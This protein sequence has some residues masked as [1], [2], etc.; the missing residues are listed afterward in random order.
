MTRR[1]FLG[2][3]V[4]GAGARVGTG[5]TAGRS[6]VGAGAATPGAR[7]RCSRRVTMRSI[8]WREASSRARNWMPI[9]G[10]TGGRAAGSSRATQR[11]TPRARTTTSPPARRISRLT[12]L[13]TG[14]GSRV[15]M[16]TP[17]R[18]MFVANRSTN[19]STEP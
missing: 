12:S 2:L 16:K 7:P 5:V 10:A 6:E 18:E 13:P 19:S 17:P 14:F 15:R 9:P 1:R 8:T 4:A 3:A 11:T